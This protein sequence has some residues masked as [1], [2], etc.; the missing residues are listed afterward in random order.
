MRTYKSITDYIEY[1]RVHS[2]E[3][4]KTKDIYYLDYCTK[5]CFLVAGKVLDNGIK[6]YFIILPNSIEIW[7]DK[8]CLYL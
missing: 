4:L 5:E 7:Y 3:N 1:P 2:I 8:P 6:E